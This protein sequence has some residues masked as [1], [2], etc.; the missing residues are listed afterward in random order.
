MSENGNTE[1]FEDRLKSAGH[2]PN[3][4]FQHGNPGGPGNPNAGSVAKVRA[5]FLAAL[6]DEDVAKALQVIRETME[7]GNKPSDRLAAALALLDRCLGRPRQ[8]VDLTTSD[9]PTYKYLRGVS[10]DDL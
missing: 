10:D 2:G 4:R 8:A 1:P 9:M 3:G 7:A 6:R 5:A